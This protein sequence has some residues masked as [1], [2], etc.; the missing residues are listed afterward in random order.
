MFSFG[1]RLIKTVD[2]TIY[3]TNMIHIDIFLQK[4]V[5]KSR[6]SE[7]MSASRMALLSG[8]VNVTSQTPLEDSKNLPKI[9]ITSD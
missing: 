2:T 3:W 9:Y 4:N 5:N 7:A 6:N 8:D 1:K